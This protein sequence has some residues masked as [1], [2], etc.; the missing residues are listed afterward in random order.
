MTGPDGTW[1]INLPDQAINGPVSAIVTTSQP[2][3]TS[4]GTLDS[5]NVFFAP[6]ADG[7]I[8]FQ[9]RFDLFS[10]REAE[11]TEALGAQMEASESPY[12]VTA[13]RYINFNE[14]A[15]T[16]LSAH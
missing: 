6:G 2:Q 3:L 9:R 8:P 5:T 16:A 1:M 4:L 15:G 12:G 7:P 10:A 13:R 11:V 14:V